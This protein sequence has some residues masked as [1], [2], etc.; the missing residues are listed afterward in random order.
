MVTRKIQVVDENDQFAEVEIQVPAFIS[1]GIEGDIA[2]VLENEIYIV[3]AKPHGMMYI[4]LGE[5]IFTE[6][7]IETMTY[8]PS[9]AISILSAIERRTKS[10]KAAALMEGFN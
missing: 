7:D 10:I 2:V 8:D 9:G 1:N 3:G 4:I 6:Q 5:C